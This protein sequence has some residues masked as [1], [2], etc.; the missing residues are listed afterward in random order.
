MKKLT[1]IKETIPLL[2][3]LCSGYNT[4]IGDNAREEYMTALKCIM[5]M[6]HNL[7]I[8][9]EVYRT[10]EDDYLTRFRILATVN[11]KPYEQ[12]VH[13]TT[14]SYD[15]YLCSLREE[16]KPITQPTTFFRR[17]MYYV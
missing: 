4:A 5:E 15:Q 9:V 11:N 8:L 2:E 7:G 6:M 13:C 10:A 1:I 16:K 12:I 14:F 3:D 17:G